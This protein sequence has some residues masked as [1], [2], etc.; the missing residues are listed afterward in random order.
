MESGKARL[1]AAAAAVVVAVV[2]LIVLQGGSGG[3][4]GS[5]NAGGKVPTIVIKGGKPAGGIAQLTYT[6]GE[7]IRFRVVCPFAEEVH[8]H[9]YDVM[10]DVRAGGSVEFDVPAEIQGVFEAELEGR[11]EQIAEITVNP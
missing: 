2:L 10:K 6:K 5:S 9:G 8:L 7:R 4:P 3:S 11:K 1:L